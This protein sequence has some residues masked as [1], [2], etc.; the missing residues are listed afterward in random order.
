MTGALLIHLRNQLQNVPFIPYY[1]IN[2]GLKQIGPIEVILPEEQDKLCTFHCSCME[3]YKKGEWKP[4]KKS[5][6]VRDNG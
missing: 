6:Q 3:R 4:K 1:K 5:M 2:D